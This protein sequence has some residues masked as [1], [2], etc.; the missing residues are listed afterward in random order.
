M[1]KYADEGSI[2]HELAAMC[3]TEGTDAAAYL[4]RVITCHDYPHSKL[5]PSGAHRWMRCAGSAVLETQ[6]AFVPREFSG[7][8]DDEMVEYVQEYVDAIRQYADGAD[9]FLVE[10]K[11]DIGHILGHDENG[12][13]QGGHG[14]VCIV[15]DGGEELQLH[16]LKY[17]RGVEVFAEDNEQL[18]LYALG[19]LRLL[20]LLIDTSKVKR[21]RLVIH[22]PRIKSGPDEWDL[23]IEDL[24]AFG[25]VARDKAKLCNDLVAEGPDAG[26]PLEEYLVPGEK[27]C[28]F[29]KAKAVCPALQRQ[30]SKDV[31]DDFDVIANPD[32]T[33]APRAVPT[34]SRRLGTLMDRLD[35]IEDWCRAVR[36]KGEAETLAGNPPIGADGPYKVVR[37]RKG[38]TAWLDTDA[39]EDALKRMRLRQDEMYSMKLITPTAAKKLLKGQPKRLATIADLYHQ[40]D[41]KL[42]VTK[43]SDKRAAVEPNDC[44]DDFEDLT[45]NAE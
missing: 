20:E 8:V 17:G 9:V 12:K 38:N 25:D 32:E 42:H 13:P 5:G 36:S 27:Q 23:P 18:L 30:V 22:Q 15:T 10:R 39:A 11:L 26:G 31:F 44:M 21:A 14:D 33:A 34:E 3:L 41:G 1:S 29:C 37:G 6:A 24:L 40:P 16:D 19:L 43:A 45:E 35:L 2:A 28:R 4:G 7:E